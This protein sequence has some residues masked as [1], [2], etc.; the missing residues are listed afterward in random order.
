MFVHQRLL[1]P[2]PEDFSQPQFL[3]LA[4]ESELYII[5][6]VLSN[7]LPPSSSL[8]QS[9]RPLPRSRDVATPWFSP[10][11]ILPH[12]TAPPAWNLLH[13]SVPECSLPA[14]TTGPGARLR[15]CSLSRPLLPLPAASPGR[16]RELSGAAPPA[17]PGMGL[18]LVPA[19]SR[20]RPRAASPRRLRLLGQRAQPLPGEPGWG[21][22]LFPPRLEFRGKN[23][24]HP[25]SSGGKEDLHLLHEESF[26]RFPLLLITKAIFPKT[27]C[28]ARGGNINRCI[29][30][31][32]AVHFCG[33]QALHWKCRDPRGMGTRDHSSRRKNP[34]SDKSESAQSLPW[35]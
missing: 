30:W 28:W 13:S 1:Q 31:K 21:Y 34:S 2:Q 25:E 10:S 32:L 23:R 24:A 12:L 26:V 8:L 29:L 35:L 19:A 33:A 14:R 20:H 18:P 17:R 15:P 7:A 11:N 16:V 5:I 6:S 3:W 4:F 22:R 27:G 9:T